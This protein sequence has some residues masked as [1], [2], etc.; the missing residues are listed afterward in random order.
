MSNNLRASWFSLL[1]VLAMA[2]IVSGDDFRLSLRRQVPSGETPARYE[3]RSADETWPAAKTA[4]IVCDV[5]DYHHCLNAVRRLDEFLPRLNQTLSEA[6]RR[7]AVIIHSPSDCMEAYA[8]HPARRRAIEA[9][10]AAKLPAAIRHWCSA[11]PAEEQ[12]VYPLDQ[13]DGGEDDDPTE[14]AEWAGK[15][16]QLGRNP[17]MPWKKQSDQIQIDERLDYITDRGDEVWN[18]L[19]AR[20]IERVLLT[21]VHVNMCV[22]GRPFGL[23]QLV[24]NGKQVALVRD[25][26]DSMY[27][28]RRWPYTDH[29]TG[30]DLIISHIER[31]VC[32][33]ITSD[34]IVGG[35]PFR[36]RHDQRA[37]RD[38]ATLPSPGGN[39]DSPAGSRKA[40]DSWQLTNL[41]KNWEQLLPPSEG[42]TKQVVWLR[43]A[44]RLPAE[45]LGSDETLV[46]APTRPGSTRVWLNGKE[47]ARYRPDDRT[48]RALRFTL[49]RDAAQVDD[50]NLMVLRIE[51]PPKAKQ[52]L[53][54]PSLVSGQRELSLQGNWQSRVGDDLSWAN[55]PLPAKFGI[56]SD[57]Q[58]EP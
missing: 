16:K 20:G 4:V 23:R 33:T 52:L 12:A 7:G 41:P 38:V 40:G 18:I 58:Y 39:G 36:F 45:W 13:S 42:D 31:Y 8:E 25:L 43:C 53:G 54:A 26:T 44:V 24:R 46:I 17:G 47:L 28:P 19:A 11:I 1:G 37:M 35:E 15:L 2:T 9:P 29:F 34:Q 6:R 49:P 10:T 57:V 55:I 51:A 56:G 48:V 27:N 21:G 30:T 3:R 50:V 22:L 5:W 14:H 32:P